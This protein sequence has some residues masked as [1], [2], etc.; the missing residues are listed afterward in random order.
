MDLGILLA[1]FQVGSLVGHCRTSITAFFVDIFFLYGKSCGDFLGWTGRTRRFSKNDRMIHVVL[2][3]SGSHTLMT[4][5]FI[6]WSFFWL[7][8]C[9]SH[10]FLLFGVP[11]FF[12]DLKMTN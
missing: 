1:A 8:F 9:H 5:I 7:F 2:E 10:V 12:F 11:M 3:E 6:I 4:L